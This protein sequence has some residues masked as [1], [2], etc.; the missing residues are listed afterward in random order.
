MTEVPS[1]EPT[2]WRRKLT[3][4][5]VLD[6]GMHTLT[7]THSENTQQQQQQQQRKLQNRKEISASMNKPRVP[8][9]AWVWPSGGLKGVSVR[10]SVNS[11][12]VFNKTG[13]LSVHI[14]LK[15]VFSLNSRKWCLVSMLGAMD[16][17][18]FYSSKLFSSFPPLPEN[19]KM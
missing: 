7:Q 4:T 10:I 8:V 13:K 17:V 16:V 9:T 5:S 12:P 15:S 11:A 6:M 14:S 18:W 1:P 2:R 3:P 19:R